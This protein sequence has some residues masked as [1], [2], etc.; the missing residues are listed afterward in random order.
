MTNER[1]RRR[2]EAKNP[3]NPGPGAWRFPTPIL[4]LE[5]MINIERPIRDRLVA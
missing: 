5:V 4:R 3:K 2:I 1:T